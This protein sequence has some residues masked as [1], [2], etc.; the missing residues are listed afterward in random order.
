METQIYATD[1]EISRIENLFATPNFHRTHAAQTNAI[2]AELAVEK[3]K[4][5]QLYKRWEGL[6]AIKTAAE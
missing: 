2:M 5:A 1:E 6:D 3:E 4:F